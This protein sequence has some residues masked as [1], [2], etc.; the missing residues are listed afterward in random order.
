MPIT[1]ENVSYVY[2]PN[3]PFS[4]HALTDI[5][6][7]IETGKITAIIGATGSGKSTLVQ[8]LN[9]LIQPTSGVVT[10]LDHKIKANDKTRNLKQLRSKVGLVFQF[11]EMQLFEETIYKDVAFGPKNFGFNEEQIQE[12]VSQSLNLVGIHP[13]IWKRSPL[14]LSGG[15]K[16]RVAIAG[17]LAT[18]PDVI[19]LDEPTAGLDPQGS[20]DMMDLFVRLNQEMKKTVIMVTHDMDHVLRYAD[21]VLVLNQGSVFYDGP[22]QDFFDDSNKLESLGFVAPKI[23]QLKQLLQK[24]GF[25]SAQSLEL[26]D[27]AKLI[28]RDL[29]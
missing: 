20:K 9:G 27:I 2:A 4:H 22:V 18:N 6:T 14:D 7:T 26:D 3:S 28:E 10:I 24:N 25:N 8:H 12:N 5:S 15:Q 21:N 13:D 17:V 16:R 23:L 1:F 11:P 29:K 19:V